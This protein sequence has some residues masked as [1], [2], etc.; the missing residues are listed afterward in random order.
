MGR[1]LLS[2]RGDEWENCPLAVRLHTHPASTAPE[3]SFVVQTF[4]TAI[5]TRGSA[6]PV[7]SPGER[8]QTRVAGRAILSHLLQVMAFSS[9]EGQLPSPSSFA[10]SHTAHRLATLLSRCSPQP[11]GEEQSWRHRHA[12]RGCGPAGVRPACAA[13][14]ASAPDC[15]PVPPWLCE[16]SSR[17][18]VTQRRAGRSVPGGRGVTSGHTVLPCPPPAGRRWFAGWGRAQACCSFP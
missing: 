3:P 12:L 15:P 14:R 11:A 18:A 10:G 7:A 9:L 1:W 2:E 6:A 5:A 4:S 16:A 17:Q 13:L 8:V